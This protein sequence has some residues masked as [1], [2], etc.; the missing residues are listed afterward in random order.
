MMNKI[1]LIRDT[2]VVITTAATILGIFIKTLNNLLLDCIRN[3]YINVPGK[4]SNFD[5]VTRSISYMLIYVSIINSFIRL[6][7]II[8]N[9]SIL[10]NTTVIPENGIQ[11]IALILAILFTFIVIYTSQLFLHSIQEA[12]KKLEENFKNEIRKQNKKTIFDNKCINIAN[13]IISIIFTGSSV[14][15]ILFVYIPNGIT[16]QNRSEILTIT[17][18]G[19]VSLSTF[20]ISNSITPI[21]NTLKNEYL[22]YLVTKS[23]TIVCEFFLEYPECYLVIENGSE[24]YINKSEVKEIKKYHDKK[25]RRN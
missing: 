19:L 13:K 12:R 7:V 2:L 18:F 17:F 21:V 1:S 11:V 6:G 23:E 3:K 5:A 16:P 14:A 4:Q 10:I 25:M 22:Y 8:Y 9:P 15:L 20:I 24:R